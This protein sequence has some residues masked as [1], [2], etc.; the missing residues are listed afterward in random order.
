MLYRSEK[1][2]A[3]NGLVNP[4]L[5]W[6]EIAISNVG[7][8]FQLFNRKLYGEFDLFYRTRTGIPATRQG[9][10]PNTFGASLPQ[11]NINSLSNRGLE[12][13]LGTE[14]RHGDLRWDISGNL[15]WSRQ[16]WNHYEEPE[17]RSEEHTSELQS[18]MRTSY[19]VF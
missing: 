3:T 1:G 5:S 6:E 16:K 4:Y 7:L 17:Y 2:I 9:S 10:L 14:G 12:V 15:A 11:E 19:A 13:M 18:L 8:D